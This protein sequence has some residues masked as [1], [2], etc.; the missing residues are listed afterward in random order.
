MPLP[1]VDDFRAIVLEN[2]PLIDVRAPVEFEKGAFA[3]AVNFP[4]LNDEERRLV[5]IRYKASGNDAAVALGEELIS[6][7]IKTERVAAWKAFVKAHPDAYLYC[8]RGGQ[9]SKISQ[10]WLAEAG[11]SIPRLKGG[12]KA[13]RNFLMRESE[14]I[15]SISQTMIIGGRTGSG[16]TL[17]LQHL[18]N[19]I[20]LEGIAK[21]RG[22]SFGRLIIPQPAQ[23]D[24]EDQLAYDLIRH[25]A[26]GHS[27]LIIEHESHNIGRIYIPQPLFDNLQSGELVILETSLEERIEITFDEYIAAAL[28]NYH[29]AFGDAGEQQWFD[30]L[31]SG[32]DRISKRLGSE[33]YLQIKTLLANSYTEQKNSGDVK[34][35]KVWIEILLNDY[36]D[37]MYDYQLKKSP[38]P[39]I[40]RGNAEAVRSFIEFQEE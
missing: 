12:Y 3:N 22:S 18:K 5:G 27:R 11:V 35:H 32:L 37:P 16:K 17:L 13:F 6:G 7:S 19:A 15:S 23:I 14:R 1:L 24:F 8:F 30:D 40:F 21:H 29:N 33:R 36:Y 28:S 4:L 10:T 26:A 39:V 38:I 20:D 9:R 31:N 2:R 25:E 34:A